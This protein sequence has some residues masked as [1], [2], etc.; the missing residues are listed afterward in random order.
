M[1]VLV[2]MDE[3]RNGG[4]E[5]LEGRSHRELKNRFLG[6]QKHRK[7]AMRARCP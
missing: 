7:T 2:K 5:A 1:V 6:L 3:R 4:W